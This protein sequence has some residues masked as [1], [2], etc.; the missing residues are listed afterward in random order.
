MLNQNRSP[1]FLTQNHCL[2]PESMRNSQKSMISDQKSNLPNLYPYVMN[3]PPNTEND[4]NNTITNVS[5]NSNTILNSTA[6]QT[7]LLT[8]VENFSLNSLNFSRP[9]CRLPLRSRQMGRMS[10][11]DQNRQHNRTRERAAR[12]QFVAAWIN[13]QKEVSSCPVARGDAEVPV[14]QS[15]ETTHS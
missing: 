12:T 15:G 3:Q 13:S 7:D 14:I 9:S 6:E 8:F 10:R 5:I 1:E 2:R 11:T 4:P